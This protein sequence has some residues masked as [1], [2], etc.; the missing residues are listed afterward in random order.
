MS[1]LSVAAIK[2][3]ARREHSAFELRQKLL[4]RNRDQETVTEDE[5]RTAW[6]MAPHASLLAPKGSVNPPGRGHHRAAQ[7]ISS[8]MA[9]K[10]W[11]TVGG[12]KY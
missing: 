6:V 9:F 7:P 10:A 12:D 5:V 4:A 8:D 2:L 11:I 3:L 1:Q